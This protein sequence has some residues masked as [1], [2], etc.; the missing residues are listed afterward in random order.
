MIGIRINSDRKRASCIVKPALMKL[1]LNRIYTR[2][3]YVFHQIVISLPLMGAIFPIDPFDT[4]LGDL[5][6]PISN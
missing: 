5:L 6:H 1:I 2:H 3:K 4:Y